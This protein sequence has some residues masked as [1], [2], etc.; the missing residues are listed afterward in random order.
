MKEAKVVLG[1]NTLFELKAV[2]SE[3][4]GPNLR[5]EVAHG[6]ITDGVAYSTTPIYAWWMFVRMVIHSLITAMQE[7]DS[8]G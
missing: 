7:N 5:N 2:F 3:S 4:V 6:L 1:E 8:N